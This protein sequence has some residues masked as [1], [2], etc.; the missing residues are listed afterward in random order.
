VLVSGGILI[1]DGKKTPAGNLGRKGSGKFR[2][3]YIN[4]RYW[5]PVI[6]LGVFL[7]LLKLD[8]EDLQALISFDHLPGETAWDVVKHKIPHAAFLIVAV[9]VT[10]IAVK[11]ELSLIPAL[12]LLTNFYLMSQLGITN[13]LRF[14]IWLV[15]GLVLY[16]VYGARHSRLKAL[17]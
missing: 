8:P 9:S 5:L 4:S 17:S 10:W 15:I 14:L 13:W 16:F 11:K 6:W 1:L 12:G 3:T 2:V 7:I